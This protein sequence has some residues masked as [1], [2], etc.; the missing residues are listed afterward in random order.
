VGYRLTHKAQSDLE[1]I[2]DHVAEQNPPAAVR[3]TRFFIQKLE[4]LATQPFSGQACEDLLPEVR[5]LVMG[6]YIAFYRA[7]DSEVLILRV[8]HGRR[9]ITAEDFTE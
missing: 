4:L 2:A 8:L 5:R 7:E 3:L 1:T 9:D 6:A